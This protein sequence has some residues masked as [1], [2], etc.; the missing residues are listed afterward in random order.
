MARPLLILSLTFYP[1]GALWWVMDL[2]PLCVKWICLLIELSV[3]AALMVAQQNLKKN[4]S[5]Q[6]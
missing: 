4:S 3:F 1:L 5:P 6:R 2:R